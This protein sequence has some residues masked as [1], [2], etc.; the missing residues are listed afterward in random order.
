MRDIRGTRVGQLLAGFWGIFGEW[1]LGKKKEGII[2]PQFPLI[3][4]SLRFI[5]HS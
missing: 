1:L 5:V 4:L 3:P 2:T